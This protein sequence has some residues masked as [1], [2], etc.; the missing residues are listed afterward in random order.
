[1][2]KI[3]QICLVLGI[4]FTLPFD[5]L[6]Q[7]QATSQEDAIRAL[8]QQYE[9]GW[10]RQDP[11]AIASMYTRTANSR[12]ADGFFIRGKSII[13]ATIAETISDYEGGTLSL[14]DPTIRLISD[15]V[16]IADGA[17]LVA[18]GPADAPP[19]GTYTIIYIRQDDG[20]WKAASDRARILA[21]PLGSQG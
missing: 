13:E 21:A 20:T 14:P 7:Q 11:A 10:N 16:A 15:E 17:W 19:R 1:M 4:A 2:R 12:G 8:I 9:D 3:E 18:G 5:G 6:A